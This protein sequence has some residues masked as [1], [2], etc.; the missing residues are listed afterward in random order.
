MAV[1]RASRVKETGSLLVQTLS[2]APSHLLCNFQLH[3]PKID[4]LGQRLVA[5]PLRRD[6]VRV[7]CASGAF[8]DGFGQFIAIFDPKWAQKD[9]FG[10]GFEG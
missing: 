6:P 2:Y 7:I 3:S 5:P 10:A 1:A 4:T 8:P 9:R